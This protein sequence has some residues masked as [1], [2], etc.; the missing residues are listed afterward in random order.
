[1]T[2]EEKTRFE[3][4]LTYTT[5]SS[6]EPTH[7]YSPT[8]LSI[9]DYNFILGLVASQEAEILATRGQREEREERI[10]KLE[11]C[12]NTLLWKLENEQLKPVTL[13]TVNEANQFLS[14]QKE[15]E[16]K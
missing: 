5:Y 16:E 6:E 11:T 8:I 2:P 13:N 15:K 3:H 12:L 7:H 10:K 4:I 14:G 9:Q 1:M